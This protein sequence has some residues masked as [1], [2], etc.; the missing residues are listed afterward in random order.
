MFCDKNNFSS[1]HFLYNYFH[2]GTLEVSIVIIQQSKIEKWKIMICDERR[3]MCLC[4][5]IDIFALL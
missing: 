2:E 5:I 3:Y 4:C 1:Y